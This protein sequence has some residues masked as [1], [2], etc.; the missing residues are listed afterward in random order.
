MSRNSTYLML[1][2]A[3]VLSTVIAMAILMASTAYVVSAMVVN[4]VYA[5][6][7]GLG[8]LFV[9]LSLLIGCQGIIKSLSLLG[10]EQWNVR[11]VRGGFVAQLGL[12]LLGLTL[13]LLALFF[14]R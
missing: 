1:N 2:S 11:M 9:L 13:Y 12:L 5:L 10:C 6:L 3:L 14:I 8:L 4:H 7:A